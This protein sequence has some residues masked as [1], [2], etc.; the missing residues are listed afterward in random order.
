MMGDYL[1]TDGQ[2][3][4]SV[5][6]DE[7]QPVP[8]EAYA[9]GIDGSGPYFFTEGCPNCHE[10][11]GWSMDGG[12]DHSPCSRACRLQLEYADRLKATP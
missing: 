2:R 1:L 5:E 7:I 10:D 8:G 6:G 3:L 4:H 12:Y 11:G 9:F